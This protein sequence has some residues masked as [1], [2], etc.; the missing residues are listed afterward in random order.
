MGSLAWL[1]RSAGHLS[2]GERLS[3]LFGGLQA[4]REGI[5]LGLRARTDERRR[6]ALSVLE[7][8]E[9][10]ILIAARDYLEAHACRPMVNHCY[11]T[12]FW[13]LAVLHEHDALTPR[14]AETAWVAAL[15]H[16]VGLDE[17]PTTGDF[18]AGG[19]QVLRTLAAEH[20]WDEDQTRDASEAIAI[21]LS[22]R[23][24]PSRSGV[25]AWA[26]NVGG[27]GELGFGPHR[28][29]LHPERVRELETR[30]T[31][32]GF[33]EAAMRLVREEARRIPDGR[34]ALLGRFFPLIMRP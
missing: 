32:D 11:R 3:L 30:Y 6:V 15:L 18:S 16:D 26:M 20:A 5:R 28:A 22:T 34:F 29:Q 7:P 17:P 31:R 25:V 13:T 12:A 21:N 23:V 8:P 4:L 2:F 10:P 33:R 1:T 14:V 24:N 19:V 27:I 9:T